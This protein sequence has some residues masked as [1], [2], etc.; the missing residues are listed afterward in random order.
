MEILRDQPIGR[1]GRAE[2]I[3]SAVPWRCSPGARFVIGHARAVD[4]GHTAH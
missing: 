4:G 2:E 1:F 3:T